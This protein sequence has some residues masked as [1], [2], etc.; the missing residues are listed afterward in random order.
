MKNKKLA[1]TIKSVFKHA[2]LL[3]AVYATALPFVSMVGTALKKPSIALSSSNLFP[4]SPDEFSLESFKIV[5]TKTGFGQNLLNSLIVTV[6]TVSACVLVTTCTGF[7]LSRFRGRYFSVYSVMLLV[8]QM[9]PT[10]LLLLP[11]YIIFTRLRLVNTLGSVTL[12][13]ITTNLAF[14]IW[15][16]R[17]FFDTIPVE[18]EQSAMVDGCTRFQAFR[19]VIIP[20]ALPGIATVA[21]FTFINAWNEYTLA[22]IF[23]RKDSLLTMTLGLQ[24]FV[25]QYGADWAS[26]MAASTIA[27]IPTLIFL[28]FAQKYLIEGMTAGAV[29][30]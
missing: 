2:F 3:L 11:L 23:L 1:R 6:L 18:L 15:M 30:G 24:K 28:F 26:L 29:K 8:L 10:M 17:G 20:L 9:F 13:Y 12:S 7:A 21:I 5:M 4:H 27:T 14:S 25:Q 16:L 19:R 22:S